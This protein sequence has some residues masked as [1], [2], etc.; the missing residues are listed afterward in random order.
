MKIGYARVSTL[1]EEQTT[2]IDAQRRRL[3]EAGCDPIF[4]DRASGGNLD[5][6]GWRELECLA[7][8]A[9]R[10]QKVIRTKGRSRNEGKKLG[11]RNAFGYRL[12][13]ASPKSGRK[14]PRRVDEDL[15]LINNNFKSRLDL[16][17]CELCRWGIKRDATIGLRSRPPV[18]PFEYP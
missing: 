13:I 7:I 10:K 1:N 16:F 14:F 17:L 15:I 3:S 4:E 11:G 8:Q 6:Q 18:E 9:I 12:C 2:S 5:R